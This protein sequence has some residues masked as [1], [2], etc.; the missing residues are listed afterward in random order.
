V[1]PSTA[2]ASTS[3]STTPRKTTGK[4]VFGSGG[5]QSSKRTEKVGIP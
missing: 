4:L 1:Q 3:Q 2:S 5:N